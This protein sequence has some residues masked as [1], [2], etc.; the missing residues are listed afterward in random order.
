MAT[1]LDSRRLQ[2]SALVTVGVEIRL[3]RPRRL[4]ELNIWDEREKRKPD[5]GAR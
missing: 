5:L 1:E 3:R 4:V 2:L